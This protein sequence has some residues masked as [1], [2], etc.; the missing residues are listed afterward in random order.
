MLFFFY[1]HG[2]L[3]WKNNASLTVNLFVD[4]NK[5]FSGERSISVKPIHPRLENN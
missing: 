4:G 2:I 5:D 1:Y 3:F